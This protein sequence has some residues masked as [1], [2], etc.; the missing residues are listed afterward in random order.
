MSAWRRLARSL[1][2]PGSPKVNR[3]GLPCARTEGR[4]GGLGRLGWLARTLVSQ[5]FGLTVP[6]SVSLTPVAVSSAAFPKWLIDRGVCDRS[7]ERRFSSNSRASCGGRDALASRREAGAL[8]SSA[9]LSQSVIELLEV[10]SP[11]PGLL[12]M[13]RDR[14]RISTSVEVRRAFL[15]AWPPQLGLT[16]AV[17]TTEA[18]GVSAQR[19][20]QRRGIQCG[21]H[22]GGGR[23]SRWG[24]QRSLADSTGQAINHRS[25]GQS[26]VPSSRSRSAEDVAG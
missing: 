11:T 23:G 13:A 7:L 19:H 12:D 9:L 24:L 4:G 15:G 22:E 25:R 10:D 3:G 21:E 20:T 17:R 14:M 2:F 5:D 6:I 1:A 8:R 26:G 18:L 16:I